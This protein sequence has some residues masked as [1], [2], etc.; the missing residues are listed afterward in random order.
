MG[1]RFGI[2]T[3]LTAAVALFGAAGALADGS[4]GTAGTPVSGS[5][6]TGGDTNLSGGDG[7]SQ[8]S[9]FTIPLSSVLQGYGSSPMLQGYGNIIL[10]LALTNTFVPTNNNV[11][12][13]S[14]NNEN[15][16]NANNAN[17]NNNNSTS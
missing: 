13:V 1:I 17:T 16:S 6:G 8:T 5:S 11:V 9:V 4:D 3:L 15:S 10:V 14:N 7:S 12:N 2:A